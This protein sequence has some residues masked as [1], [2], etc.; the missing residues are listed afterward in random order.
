MNSGLKMQSKI[1]TLKREMSSMKNQKTNHTGTSYY[2][3]EAI[4]FAYLS[5]VATLCVY[6]YSNLT[7][8]AVSLLSL[9]PIKILSTW[10]K[11][12]QVLTKSSYK[13]DISDL[14]ILL[15]KE[16]FVPKS[17]GADSHIFTTNLCVFPNSWC[18]VTNDGSQNILIGSN[19]LISKLMAKRK[20]IK[21][22]KESNVGI[23]NNQ[24]TAQENKRRKQMT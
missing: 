15:G 9:L 19:C 18:I 13:G 2:K 17:I 11:P 6:D 23:K 1:K 22:R 5:I 21:L 3:L 24:H 10:F 7:L 20:D 12:A 4:I 8:L 16:G 14:I